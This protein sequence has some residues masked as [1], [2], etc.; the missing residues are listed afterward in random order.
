M[1]PVTL[2]FNTRLTPHTT[3]HEMTHSDNEIHLLLIDIKLTDIKLFE[4]TRECAADYTAYDRNV[5]RKH[6]DAALEFL[7]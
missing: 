4:T 6:N 3:T 7:R 2:Q 5:V 1:L